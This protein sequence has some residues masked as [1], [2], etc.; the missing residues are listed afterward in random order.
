MPSIVYNWKRFWCPR[1][2]HFNLSDQ[3]YLYDPDSDWGYAYNPDVVTFESIANTPCLVLLGEPGIGKSYALTAE[4]E[5]V[6]PKIEEEGGQTLHLDLRQ[7]GSEDRLVGNLFESCTFQS[8]AS[9]DSVLHL[10]LD[11]L[12]ECLL[13]LDN[14]AALLSEELPKIPRREASPPHCLS[15]C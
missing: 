6:V 9:G 4:Y 5:A 8:W 2:G 12:D 15:N 3:G 13:R 1:A 10:F 11:S 7:Y 14:L